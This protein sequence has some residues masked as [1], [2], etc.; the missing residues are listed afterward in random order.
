MAIRR[1][2]NFVIIIYKWKCLS[3]IDQFPKFTGVPKVPSSFICVL[4]KSERPIVPG[5]S[6]TKYSVFSSGLKIGWA[7]L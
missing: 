5:I 4:N 7:V 3:F 6:E 2:I 1:K